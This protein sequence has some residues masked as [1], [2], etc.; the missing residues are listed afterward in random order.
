MTGRDEFSCSIKIGRSNGVSA[1]REIGSTA[2][3]SSDGSV[4]AVKDSGAVIGVS[5]ATLVSSPECSAG[6]A[7]PSWSTVRVARRRIRVELSRLSR[8]SSRA[9]II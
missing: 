5:A 4:G 3:K 1:V 9:V 7:S 6:G 8:T 2:G